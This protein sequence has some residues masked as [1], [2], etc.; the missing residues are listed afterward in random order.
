MEPDFR[1]KVFL[2]FGEIEEEGNFLG[3]LAAPNC[4]EFGPCQIVGKNVGILVLQ[5]GDRPCLPATDTGRQRL[6]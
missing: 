3:I 6:A 5:R 4:F 1:P 2:K